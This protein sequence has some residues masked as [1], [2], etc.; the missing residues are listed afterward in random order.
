M[1]GWGLKPRYSGP[2]GAS[3]M[4]LGFLA[5]GRTEKR[6]Y[7]CGAAYIYAQGIH[8]WPPLSMSSLH[9]CL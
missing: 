1:V 9:V 5:L 3:I 2:I 8:A 7:G 6:G 4:G